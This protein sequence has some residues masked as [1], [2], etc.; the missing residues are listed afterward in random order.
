MQVENHGIRKPTAGERSETR[1]GLAD[2]KAESGAKSP[3]KLHYVR[4]LR[5]K[6]MYP[7]RTLYSQRWYK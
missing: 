3:A 7:A 5:R 6:S 2:E 4:I 1:A